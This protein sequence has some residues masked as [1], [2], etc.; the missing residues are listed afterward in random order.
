MKNAG[1]DFFVTRQRLSNIR[2]MSDDILKL[3]E[4]LK[5]TGPTN[6][7]YVWLPGGG[8]RRYLPVG[9]LVPGGKGDGLGGGEGHLDLRQ[10]GA[11]LVHQALAHGQLTVYRHVIIYTL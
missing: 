5:F 11:A 10:P 1:F 9:L 4:L 8:D 2:L 6:L 7:V 3:T